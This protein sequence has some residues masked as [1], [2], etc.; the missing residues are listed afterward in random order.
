MQNMIQAELIDILL[1]IKTEGPHI[2]VGTLLSPAVIS[3]LWNLT[4]GVQIT[5]NDTQLKKVLHLLSRRTKL[6]DMSGGI[7]NMYP[8]LRFIIPERS[9]YKL[10]LELNEEM[11]QFFIEVIREHYVNWEEGKNDDVIY[12]FISEMKK[13]RTNSHFTGKNSIKLFVW[14]L[15]EILF[16]TK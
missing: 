16:D 3:V 7:L 14:I 12:A 11:K 4:T 6:F 15:D 2:E 8:W 5:K 1:F 9:G 10:M 13:N